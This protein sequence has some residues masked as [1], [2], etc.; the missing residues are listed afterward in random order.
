MNIYT[1]HFYY[2]FTLAV[3]AANGNQCTLAVYIDSYSAVYIYM[4]YSQL[5]VQ[6]AGNCSIN[7]NASQGS[8]RDNF[9]CSWPNE[10]QVHFHCTPLGPSFT[11]LSPLIPTLFSASLFPIPSS[12][13]VHLWVLQFNLCLWACNPVRWRPI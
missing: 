2:S 13:L 10:F 8:L 4:L 7:R 12:T 11:T 9:V 5:F 3:L 6:S 1:L